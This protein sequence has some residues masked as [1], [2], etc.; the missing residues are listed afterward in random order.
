MINPPAGG[1]TWQDQANRRIEKIRKGDFSVVVLDADGKPLAD[2][3][4]QIDQ[5]RSAFRWG[6]AINGDPTSDDPLEVKYRRFILDHFN[7]LVSEN[8]F[9]WYTVEKERD[10]LDYQRA[11]AY[12]KFADAHGLEMRGHC[13]FWSKKKW[14]QKWVW[15]LEGQELR[16]EIDEHIRNT[17]SR[18]KG[19]LIAWDVNNEMLDG[20]FFKDKL[21]EQIRV[22]MFKEARKH[23]PSVPLYVNEYAIL[24]SDDYASNKAGQYIELIR[25]LRSDGAPVTGIGIQEHACE[26]IIPDQTDED[27]DKHV[28]RE[29]RGDIDPEVVWK[30]LDELGKFGLP[31]HLTEVSA[32]ADDPVRRGKAIVAFMRTCFAHEAVDSFLLWGFWQRRHWLGMQASLTDNDMELNEAGKAVSHALLNE[33]RTSTEAKTD[34]RGRV[35]FRGFYGTYRISAG[36]MV[37]ACTLTKDNPTVRV[38]LEEQGN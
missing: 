33:W 34:A 15:P 20:H 7:T 16:K 32:R 5:T 10:K 6:V 21:G 8:H 18:Y 9:K 28:E 13:L 24:G 30:R 26:R 12:M 38:T 2:T 17:V 25:K 4:V 27:D 23:D 3:V 37:E 19:R 35:T 14:T 29:N 31:I 22:H 11:D 1:E 36:D